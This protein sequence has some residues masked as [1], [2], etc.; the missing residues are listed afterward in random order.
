MTEGVTLQLSYYEARMV[1][2]A[3]NSKR[4]KFT[5]ERS[6]DPGFKPEPGKIDK[7]RAGIRMID[8]IS[9]RLEAQIAQANPG[10]E[11]G[12]DQG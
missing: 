8:Q 4:R 2:S 10:D 1:R 5:Q 12:H 7:N 9:T 3:L 6:R 11:D